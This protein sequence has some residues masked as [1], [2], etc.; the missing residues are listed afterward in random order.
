LPADFASWYL[1]LA[2]VAGLL[3]GSFLNVCIY[4]LPRDLSIVSPR[5]FCPE[6]GSPI[7]WFD[8]I[9]IFSY[10]ALRGRC[11]SCHKPIGYRYPL[12][13]FT[14]AALFV[15]VAAR[16]G[17]SLNGLKWAVFE[18]LMVALFWTDLEER[19]LPELLTIGGSFLGIVFAGF[20]MMHGALEEL[21]L[22]GLK[23]VWRSLITAVVSAVMLAGPIWLVGVAYA[24]LR[25]KDGLGLG[26]VILL[27]LMGTFLGLERGVLAVLIGSVSGSV[28]GG[29]YIY[30]TG[31][32]AGSYE[33]PFGSF[34]CA[35]AALAPLMIKSP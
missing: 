9:P 32:E 2:A 17:W 26:D 29:A 28:V 10:A 16:Y 18:S 20:V 3:I 21:F 13:E 33:L 8:N 4:R 1:L 14:T 6:C 7:R 12:V 27:F 25:K 35:G 30:F 5:S 11:R 23:P 31:Q 22:S 24:R 34:L 19:I 15:C